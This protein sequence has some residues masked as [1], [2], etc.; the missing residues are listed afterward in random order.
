MKRSIEVG[1]ANTVE[2]Y[3][4]GDQYTV[5][6]ASLRERSS[7]LWAESQSLFYDVGRLEDLYWHGPSFRHL[8]VDM[9]E[10]RKMKKQ[11]YCDEGD[12]AA[13]VSELREAEQAA[14]D[15]SMPGIVD[16][17]PA[18]LQPL[19]STPM[20]L[21]MT[22]RAPHANQPKG[23]IKRKSREGE[24]VD[25]WHP[26]EQ[27]PR[28]MLKD[29]GPLL[30][31]SAY[32]CSPP[33]QPMANHGIASTPH[34]GLGSPV[35]VEAFA[36]VEAENS[37][38]KSEIALMREKL[39]HQALRQEILSV[40][41]HTAGQ[42]S[43]AAPL[44]H[45][46]PLYRDGPVELYYRSLLCEEIAEM[47]ERCFRH[48]EASMVHQQDVQSHTFGAPL[49]GTSTNELGSYLTSPWQS[50]SQL[51]WPHAAWQKL[52]LHGDSNGRRE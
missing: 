14:D 11:G 15:A 44:N 52:P 6:L 47:R 13:L 26:C 2:L 27:P 4:V 17:A 10:F 42:L 3:K 49:P 8:D 41:E 43:P 33:F 40:R 37:D 36:E 19:A 35:E 22:S 29:A 21:R 1:K 28:P 32:P 5:G 48:G 39:Q 25:V 9:E 34:W 46:V 23:K 45:T 50:G 38:L 51:L 30:P 18:A 16:D 20:S 7:H 12:V 31:R 24:F